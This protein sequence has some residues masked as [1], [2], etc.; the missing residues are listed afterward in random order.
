MIISCVGFLPTF[1]PCWINLYG[2]TRNYSLLEE[3]SHLNEGLDEGVS[4]RGRLLVSLATEILD[5]PDVGPPAVEVETTLPLSTVS[6]SLPR[7]NHLVACCLYINYSVN[8]Q[9][10]NDTLLFVCFCNVKLAALQIN[11]LTLF[12]ESAK[13]ITVQLANRQCKMFIVLSESKQVKVL[14]THRLWVPQ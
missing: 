2:S 7:H 14:V 9:F 3:H 1:G 10:H 5:G 13:N 11:V 8:F 6:V 12:T 4:Y